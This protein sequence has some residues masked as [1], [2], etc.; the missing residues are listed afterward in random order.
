LLLLSI[1]ALAAGCAL[2]RGDRNGGAMP[3]SVTQKLNAAPVSLELTQDASSLPCDEARAIAAAN[4]L[5]VQAPERAA[6]LWSD[7]QEIYACSPL[8]AQKLATWFESNSTFKL[9]F[10]N[11]KN[12][13]IPVFGDSADGIYLNG[14]GKVLIDTRVH[15]TR[16]AC[17]VLFHELVH[18]FD[19]NVNAGE[20]SLRTEYRANYYQQA[21]NDEMILYHP[22]LA[23]SAGLPNGV[24]P[25]PGARPY[26]TRE[27]LLLAVANA[28]GF[29][30]DPMIV[31]HYPK[32]PREPRIDSSMP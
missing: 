5:V 17:Y 24:P 6:E 3:Q 8:A 4:R 1:L 16:Q 27:S 28:Y 13:G 2:N 14:T 12:A 20:M 23:M 10:A 9:G 31:R 18:R 26:H 19:T 7:C 29:K 25:N 11:L 22:A 15:E 21:Y 30:P 32:L